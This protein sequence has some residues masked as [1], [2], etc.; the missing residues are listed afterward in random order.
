ME[1]MAKET[2]TGEWMGES[3]NAWLTEWPSDQIVWLMTEG[4]SE[5]HRDWM[6]ECQRVSI[7]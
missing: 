3:E 5:W 7:N 6:N 2:L 4:T 1:I